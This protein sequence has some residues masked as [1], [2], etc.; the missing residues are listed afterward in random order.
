MRP[1]LR[2][3]LKDPRT[4]RRW[5]RQASG[6]LMRPPPLLLSLR[7]GPKAGLGRRRLAPHGKLS[8]RPACRRSQRLPHRTICLGREAEPD[9]RQ[10]R[11]RFAPQPARQAGHPAALPA[12]WRT[13]ARR[14]QAGGPEAGRPDG[15]GSA[16]RMRTCRIAR[17]IARPRP[18]LTDWKAHRRRRRRSHPTKT[19][20]KTTR[21]SHR[22]T[23]SKRQ[24]S[25]VGFGR[26]RRRR[27][28]RAPHQKLL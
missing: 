21:P 3:P 23:G 24:G 4:R 19:R 17:P 10:A 18:R 7:R 20:P 1:I 6:I 9:L 2:P 5:R 12:A 27:S 14:R 13:E 11:R 22:R 25:P 8:R 16:R 15:S 26:S 28:R